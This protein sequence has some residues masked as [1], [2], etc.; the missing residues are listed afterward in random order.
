MCAPSALQSAAPPR[1]EEQSLH[2]PLCG[3]DLRGLSQPR[4]PECGSRFEW[5]ELRDPAKKLH[6]YLFEHHPERNVSSFV[7]TFLGGLRPGKFWATLLPIQPSR[8]KRLILYALICAAM[9]LLGLAA[10]FT[11]AALALRQQ[12]LYQR[13][14]TLPQITGGNTGIHPGMAP[15]SPADALHQLW[16]RT[17]VVWTGRVYVINDFEAQRIIQTYGS[18]Q[19]YLDQTFPLPPS[20]QFFLQVLK[21]QLGAG[22]GGWGNF[23]LDYTLHEMLLAA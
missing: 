13:A 1:V 2:C 18:I 20:S 22:V 19:N 5:A 4:C 17:Q 12:N 21:S 14:G 8:P 7:Q 15:K 3:Y 6:P 9:L 11:R 16:L 23:L 10:E